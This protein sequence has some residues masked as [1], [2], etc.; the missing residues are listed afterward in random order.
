LASLLIN[1]LRATTSVTPATNKLVGAI[2][3]APAGCCVLLKETITS[4]NQGGKGFMCQREKFIF[5]SRHFPLERRRAAKD[6]FAQDL[7]HKCCEQKNE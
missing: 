1:N 7:R 6:A 4:L 3:A 2:G 5:T